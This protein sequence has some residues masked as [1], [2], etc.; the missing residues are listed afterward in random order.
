MDGLKVK[1]D[2]SNASCSTLRYDSSSGTVS[3][4]NAQATIVFKVCFDEYAHTCRM[5]RLRSS[6]VT[7]LGSAALHMQ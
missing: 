6:P 2:Y 1:I 5:M 4:T 3:C 7:R